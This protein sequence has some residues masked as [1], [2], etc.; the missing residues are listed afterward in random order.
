MIKP[1]PIWEPI[2]TQDGKLTRPWALW[3]QELVKEINGETTT[4]LDIDVSG[5]GSISTVQQTYN[6]ITINPDTVDSTTGGGTKTNGFLVDHYFGGA[7][8]RGG[9]HALYGYLEQQ[10]ATEAVNTDRNYAAVVGQFIGKDDDTGTGGSEKGGGFGGNF[11][12]GL[13]SGAT[14]WLNLTACEFNTRARTGSSVKYKTGIQVHGID[15]VQGSTFDCMISLSNTGQATVGWKHG[16]L[17]SALG[18]QHP[19]DA[20]TGT[21][22]GTSGSATV[23]YGIDISSYTCTTAAFKSTNVE[24]KDT[25]L[26]LTGT[27]HGIDIG[28]VG[29]ANTPFMD[30]H[31]SANSIDYNFRMIASGGDGTV[32]TGAMTFLGAALSLKDGFRIRTNTA[33]ASTFKLSAYDVDGAAFTDFITLTANNNPTCDITAT[34][35]D[36]NTNGGLILS[37]QTDGAGAATGTLNNAPSAGDPDFWEKRIINGTAG[38]SPVWFA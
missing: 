14:S 19:I 38:W 13:N 4:A 31:S 18:S 33:A 32:G 34:T 17:F 5:S 8:T 22:I 30:W 15:D 11:Y 23:N 6:Q 28:K 10:A 37:N 24:I 26:N 29:T 27:N 20:T 36:I 1:A 7:G 25:Q 12:A 2:K 3:M 21:L 16:V 9:R 35:I